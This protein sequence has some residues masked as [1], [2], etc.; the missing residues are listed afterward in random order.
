VEELRERAQR[1]S[2]VFAALVSSQIKT[3]VLGA[4]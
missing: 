3:S 1:P 2:G 4:A